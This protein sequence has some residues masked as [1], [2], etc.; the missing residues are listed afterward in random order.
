VSAQRT[1]TGTRPPRL[2]RDWPRPALALRWLRALR[3]ETIRAAAWAYRACRRVHRS[4]GVL[5]GPSL[6]RVPDVPAAAFAGVRHVL[7]LR[8]ERCLVSS[9]VRQSWLAA[10]G[11]PRELVIGTT[12]PAGFAAHAWLAGEDDIEGVGFH[13]LVRLAPPDAPR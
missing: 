8:G 9:Y 13:E 1:S 2:R 11:D 5:S 3:P 4:E 10:H 7:W 12:G 6:P